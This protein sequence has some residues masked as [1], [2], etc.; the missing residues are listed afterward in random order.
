MQPYCLIVRDKWYAHTTEE[1]S[2]VRTVKDA[3]HLIAS[4]IREMEYASDVYPSCGEISEISRAVPPLLL[5]FISSLVQSKLKQCSLAQ[6]LIQAARPQ[7]S[8]TPLVFGLAV[9]LDH[10][11]GSEFLL[12]QLSRLGFCASY[13]E[14]TRFKTSL[15]SSGNDRIPDSGASFTQ[16]VGCVADNIDHNVRAL[17]GNNRFQCIIARDAPIIGISP[18]LYRYRPIVIYYVL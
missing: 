5:L 12:Q 17:D 8:I 18:L 14:V 2:S 10:E 6:A 15:M 16:F 9:Q 4:E 1:N 7:T 13:D 3:V 11:F